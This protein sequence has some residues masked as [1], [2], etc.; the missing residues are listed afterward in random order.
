MATIATHQPIALPCTLSDTGPGVCGVIGKAVL[1]SGA[2][3]RMVGPATPE[4]ALLLSA[5]HFPQGSGL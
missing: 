5:E 2:A 3:L 1:A 4:V